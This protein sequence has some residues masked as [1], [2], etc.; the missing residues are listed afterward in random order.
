MRSTFHYRPNGVL[1]NVSRDIIAISIG[2][3][4]RQPDRF[5]HPE[6]KH[7]WPVFSDA[8]SE[9]PGRETQ[10]AETAGILP[11]ILE[12]FRFAH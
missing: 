4:D 9:F 6:N 3:I 2:D 11:A 10:A 5:S 7:V 12:S 1:P 8:L